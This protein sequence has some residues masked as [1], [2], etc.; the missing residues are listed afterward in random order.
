M[1]KVKDDVLL[2]ETGAYIE[3][4]QLIE[5][6]RYQECFAI[7]SGSG[8]T[9]LNLFD[10]TEIRKGEVAL[11]PAKARKIVEDLHKQG[12]N[13]IGIFQA[14]PKKE[15]DKFIPDEDIEIFNLSLALN[16]AKPTM[17]LRIDPFAKRGDK[18]I[19]AFK[20]SLG[21]VF[22]KL[23]PKLFDTKEREVLNFTL[24]DIKR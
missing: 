1:K 6:H 20:Y 17:N 3:L 5:K 23:I 8:K 24:K 21:K 10:I 18:L 14:N 16:D 11:D 15:A 13:F 7:M 19:Y 2:L 22:D 4:K 12:K 9:V